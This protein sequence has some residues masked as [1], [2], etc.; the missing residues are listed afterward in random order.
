[1]RRILDLHFDPTVIKFDSTEEY[2]AFQMALGRLVMF[3]MT[4]DSDPNDVQLVQLFV[5]S[6]KEFTGVYHSHIER[7]DSYSENAPLYRIDDAVE[8]IR[9]E[10]CF[11]LGGIPREGGKSY[12]FH[13]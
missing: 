2:E 5:D 11:V 1:M 4:G 12:S 3:G 9:T 7:K 6:H 13:S 10:G 8:G